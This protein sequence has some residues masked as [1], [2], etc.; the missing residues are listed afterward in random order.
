MRRERC[1][2]RCAS[3]RR[4]RTAIGIRI[5]VIGIRASKTGREAGAGADVVSRVSISSTSGPLTY[6]LTYLYRDAPAARPSRDA[7]RPGPARPGLAPPRGVPLVR[8]MF[9]SCFAKRNEKDKRNE[10]GN[11]VAPA[12]WRCAAAC[13]WRRPAGGALDRLSASSRLA[14]PSRAVGRFIQMS[15]GYCTASRERRLMDCDRRATVGACR[16]RV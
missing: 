9:G 3:P 13:A 4:A 1:P 5:A 6:L 7:R 11:E 2:C 10:H 8:S 16:V 14:V 15:R 12:R